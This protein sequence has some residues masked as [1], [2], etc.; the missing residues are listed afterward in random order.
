MYTYRG[1]G[2]EKVYILYTYL[3]VDNYGWPLNRISPTNVMKSAVPS[4]D[5]EGVAGG[6]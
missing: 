3:N 6:S 5:A 1:G 2:T 4:T